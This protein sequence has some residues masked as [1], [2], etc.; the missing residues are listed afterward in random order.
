[1]DIKPLFLKIYKN[2]QLIE[3]KQFNKER[4]LLG[5]GDV[6]LRLEGLLPS[7]A[8]I[9]KESDGLYHVVILAGVEPGIFVGGQQIW[10]Y[11]LVSYGVFQLGYYHIEF[12]EM[13]SQK[14]SILSPTTVAAHSTTQKPVENFEKTQVT[15]T[16]TASIPLD[17]SVQAEQPPFQPQS[18]QMPS[19]P[20][21]FVQAGQVAPSF[22]S[23]QVS[24]PESFTFKQSG[25]TVHPHPSQT[26]PVYPEVSSQPFTQR[27]PVPPPQSSQVPPYPEVPSQ[28][29]TQKG[30]IPPPQSSQ[31]PPYP[32]VP[33][34]TFTQKGP[35]PPPQSSQVPPYP[36]VPSQTFTQK[37]PIPPPQSSQVPPYPEVPSQTFTQKGPIPPPQSSQVPPYPEVPS[38]TF[39]QRGTV[40]PSQSPQAPPYPEMF[41]QTQTLTQN[42]LVPPLQGP[43]AP[44]NEP[45]PDTATQVQENLLHSIQSDMS[46]PSPFTLPTKVPTSALIKPAQ[47]DTSTVQEESSL[48]RE[49]IDTS[50]SQV[51][52]VEK[53]ISEQQTTQR[54]SHRK[55]RTFADNSHVRDINERIQPE[56]GSVVKVIVTWN[57]K[58]LNTL[59]F[60][61]NSTVK[62]GSHPKNDIILPVFSHSKD[63]HSLIKIKKLA[64]LFVTYEMR[65]VLVKG[66][67]KITFDDMMNSGAASRKDT[68]FTIDLQRGE[69]ARVDF[70]SGIS[71]FVKYTVPSPKPLIGPFFD[72]TS[73]ELNT[74]IMAIGSSIIMAIFFLIAHEP[75]VVELEEEVERK[76]IFVYKPPPAPAIDPMPVKPAPP[77]PPIKVRPRKVKKLA[78]KARAPTKRAKTP[79]KQ[80]SVSKKKTKVAQQRAKVGKSGAAGRKGAKANR[81][82]T[83]SAN[84]NA[85]N[86]SGRRGNRSSKGGGRTA[87]RKNK[88]D[89]N[90]SG[91]LGAFAKGG[92]QDSLR[93]AFDGAGIVENL[94]QRARGRSGGSGG[95]RGGIAS[96]GGL[97][98]IGTDGRGESTYGIG[99]INTKGRGGGG[100]IKGFGQGSLGG[101]LNVRVDVSG[102]AGESFE[103]VIDKEAIRRVVKRNVKQ[104]RTCYERLAQKDPGASGRVDLN[105]TIEANGRVGSVKVVKSQIKDQSTLDC[106]KLRLAAWR[107]PDPPEG[108]IGDINYPFVF[109]ISRQ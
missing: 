69:L 29:F 22:Q 36:E 38:Q 40:P 95:G 2:R 68:G 82:A 14:A 33:S 9:Q 11:P 67:E 12:W 16:Q 51:Q 77:K 73:G 96:G 98:A 37:G 65:G 20:E 60:D 72:F 109:V 48:S 21:A 54:G 47:Q 35:V 74:I 42:T 63:S 58:I 76:A 101:K 100:G 4:I 10:R 61:Y 27:G 97:S 55:K 64:S 17:A 71:I 89:V 79:T 88:K 44:E 83:A 26:P 18:P 57:D 86:N 93:E 52:Q 41:T 107:F 5:S 43:Q 104:L 13:L 87:G 34:Q 62:V 75:E 6:D 31:V 19:Y 91:L 7:H 90:K 23:P 45:Y 24:S 46:R 49:N 39:T 53:E 28:T 99:A 56:S 59:Y 102:G 92:Q 15:T 25:Q 50:P 108:V 66:S 70:D 78:D 1:M 85:K 81:P 84:K 103:G 30:P 8:V 80:K 94:A 106:M 32:E 3:V 105:W